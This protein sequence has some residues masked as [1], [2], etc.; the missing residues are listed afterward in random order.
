[1]F[2]PQCL[3]FLEL[4]GSP[5]DTQ[6]DRFSGPMMLR[7]TGLHPVI[8]EFFKDPT[9]GPWA[10]L[11]SSAFTFQ[12]PFL[13]E[14]LLLNFKSHHMTQM[15]QIHQQVLQR[16]NSIPN[17]IMTN[18]NYLNS[19]SPCTGLSKDNPNINAL[20]IFFTHTDNPA[21]PGSSHTLFVDSN[22]FSC[23][24]T[25]SSYSITNTP[26]WKSQFLE[27]IWVRKIDKMS[28]SDLFPYQLV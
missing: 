14:V 4:E 19:R 26:Y 18:A 21:L 17:V 13:I 16:S 1:M 15:L 22:T 7:S 11:F 5:G 27:H 28:I 24:H 9:C 23:Y 8:L 6:A 25:K 2:F 12:T 3:L 20:H 10:A